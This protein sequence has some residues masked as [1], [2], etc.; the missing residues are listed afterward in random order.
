M[1][2]FFRDFFLL[3][4]L[5]FLDNF[6]IFLDFSILEF[7]EF[8]LDFFGFYGLL[9][10]LLLKDTTGK[11]QSYYWK[12]K[13]AKNGPKQHN[14]VFFCLKGKKASSKG[15]SPLQELEVGPRSGLYLLVFLTIRMSCFP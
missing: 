12:P 2:D 4:F 6:K 7:L 15:R 10:K 11:L 8:V 9:L 5:I 3:L 13:M 1:G 14:N